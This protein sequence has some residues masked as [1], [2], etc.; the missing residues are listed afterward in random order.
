MPKKAKTL[1]I[2]VVIFA[3]LFSTGCNEINRKQY[4]YL[5][6]TTVENGN[7]CFEFL[8]ST[9]SERLIC[10]SK[11]VCFKKKNA[12]P[13]WPMDSKEAEQTRMQWLRTHLDD[14][15]YADYTYQITSRQ[16]I[17]QSQSKYDIRYDVIVQPNKYIAAKNK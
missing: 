11:N 13:L 17:R 15:G 16:T 10:D 4:S 2:S 5:C 14:C 9:G 7:Q 1:T 12:K 8:A 6:K 3:I